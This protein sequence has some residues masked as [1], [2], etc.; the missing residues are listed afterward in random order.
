MTQ[1][2]EKEDGTGGFGGVVSLSV[3]ADR[4]TETGR[5]ATGPGKSAWG[6]GPMRTLVIGDDLWALDYQGLSRFDLATLEGG[7]AVDLP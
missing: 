7:W 4:L 6:E 1:W 5:V 3:G 2:S